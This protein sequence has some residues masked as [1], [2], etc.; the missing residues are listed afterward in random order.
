[1]TKNV[2]CEHKPKVNPDGEKCRDVDKNMEYEV[3]WL[4]K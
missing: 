3:N 2:R 1:M 4:Q